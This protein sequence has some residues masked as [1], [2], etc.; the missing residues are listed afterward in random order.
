M[1]KH[2]SALVAAAFFGVSALAL[3]PAAAENAAVPSRAVSKTLPLAAGEGVTVD[4]YKGSVRV[5][6]GEGEGV[7]V[8]AKIVADDGDCWSASEQ[9]RRVEQTRV[10]VVKAVGGVAITSNYDAL[11]ASAHA[12]FG[13]TARPFVHYVIRMP[14]SA[15]LRI[16]DYKSELSVRGLEADLQVDTYKGRLDVAALAGGLDVETYKG[17]VNASI[18]RLA[19]DIRAQT[20][21][22][23]IVLHLP[24]SAGFELSADIGRRGALRSDFATT[25]ATGSA[26]RTELSRATVNGGGPRVS[27]KTDKGFLAVRKG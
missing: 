22:G 7:S 16:K 17:E 24:G 14:K 20:Y 26:R 10:D 9:A 11:E 2:P 4:T 13:C 19:G 6:A 5:T 15:R 8:E 1:R 3:R 25:V 23:S 27:L 12:F 21:K 18:T